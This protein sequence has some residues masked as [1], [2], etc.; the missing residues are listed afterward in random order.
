MRIRPGSI[1]YTLCLAGLLSVARVAKADAVR[2][3]ESDG[4]HVVVEGIVVRVDRRMQRLRIRA[5]GPAGRRS[6]EVSYSVATR[7][8]A[9]DQAF[10][11]S[12][13]E[14]GYPVRIIERT[15]NRRRER[16]RTRPMAGRVEIV[17]E[18]WSGRIESIRRARNE[19][20]VVVEESSGP[21]KNKRPRVM[22]PGTDEPM[23]LPPPRRERLQLADGVELFRGDESVALADIEAGEV[24]RAEVIPAESGPVLLRMEIGDWVAPL[25]EEGGP[26]VEPVPATTG[27][28]HR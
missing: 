15:V 28:A 16:R 2:A 13:V 27:G 21:A 12:Q 10:S 8:S 14:A 22:K 18:R 6:V 1:C 4:G 23:I 17:T 24:Y 19:L 3:E 9:G 5:Y 25:A 7:W 26:L 20:R 11:V